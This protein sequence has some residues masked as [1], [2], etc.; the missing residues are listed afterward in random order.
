VQLN[1]RWAAIAVV[2]LTVS[3]CSIVEPPG[4]PNVVTK[5]ESSFSLTADQPVVVRTLEYTAT[6]GEMAVRSISGYIEVVGKGGGGPGGETHDDVWISIFNAETGKSS[7]DVDG[8]GH[9]SVDGWGHYAPCDGVAVIASGALRPDPGPPCTARWTVVARWL[10][11]APGADIPLELNGNM[12]AYARD[13]PRAS[14]LF[15]LLTFSIAQ[16]GDPTFSGA[17][18]TSRAGVTGSARVT[19][20]SAPQTMHYLLRVPAALLHGPAAYP[21]L[22]RIFVGSTVGEWSGPPADARVSLSIG[23]RVTEPYGSTAGELDWLGLCK[24]DVTCELPVDVTVSFWEST[25]SGKTSP[26]DG[27]MALEWRVEARLEDF[28]ANATM[29]V[30]LEL[31]AR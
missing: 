5:F 1:P 3:A 15:A 10:D 16:R 29:P 11:P 12:R 21:R 19:P 4:P 28:S 23:G 31:V 24:P 2:A 27:V 25:G 8:I 22:G 26:P 13:V 30:G 6:P 20:T 17:P 18:A 9:A 14:N 7:E